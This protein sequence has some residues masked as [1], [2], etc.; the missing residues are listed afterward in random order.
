MTKATFGSGRIE[1]RV[2]IPNGVLV[3]SGSGAFTPPGNI[4]SITILSLTASIANP[5][6]V[7]NA[8]GSFTITAANRSYTWAIDADKD[9][10]LDLSSF[11]I[12]CGGT[13]TA[14]VI[15]TEEA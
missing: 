9:T 11:S 6:T 10:W 8:S 5:I 14:H 7:T 2:L 13:S 4:R 12:T 15:W 1:D 3:T